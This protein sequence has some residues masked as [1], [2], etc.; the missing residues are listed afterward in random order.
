MDPY[1]EEDV[2]PEIDSSFTAE[3]A[4]LQVFLLRILVVL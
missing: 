2:L 3:V 1:P 4:R